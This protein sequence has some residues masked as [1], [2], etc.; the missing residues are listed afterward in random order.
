M[1]QLRALIAFA[2]PVLVLFL[3]VGVLDLAT[4]FRYRLV[5]HFRVAWGAST[6]R[7]NSLWGA[8]PIMFLRKYYWFWPFLVVIGMLS[9]PLALLFILYD[10][11]TILYLI[12]TKDTW[13][14]MREGRKAAFVH[15]KGT[16]VE[17]VLTDSRDQEL[18][19]EE[20]VQ[21]EEKYY[22]ET[23]VVVS[24]NGWSLTVSDAYGELDPDLK[25]MVDFKHLAIDKSGDKFFVTKDRLHEFPVKGPYPTAEEYSQW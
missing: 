2:I 17:I 12:Y 14:Q 5:G 7:M 11:I 9:I 3:L 15:A 4:G 19:G 25:A 13:V 1:F 6:L 23:D 16:E 24:T 21:A 10:F 8:A 18:E 20:F 22:R